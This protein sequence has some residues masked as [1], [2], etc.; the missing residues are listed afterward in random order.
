MLIEGG[1][2]LESE[3]LPPLPPKARREKLEA[4]APG[5]VLLPPGIREKNAWHPSYVCV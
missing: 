3:W 4:G 5:R 2:K 1:A